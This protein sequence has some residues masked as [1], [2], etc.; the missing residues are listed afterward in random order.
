MEC[1]NT[2][3]G[4][5][6]GIATAPILFS[7]DRQPPSNFKKAGE[8]ENIMRKQYKE[9]EY[10]KKLRDPR[11]QKMRLKIL[12]RDEFTCQ[13]CMDSE[14][15]LHVHH[16]YYNKGNDPWDY[17]YTSLVTLC[18]AC[19]EVE[20]NCAYTDK[21]ALIEVLS[22]LGL[23]SRHFNEIVVSIHEARN[24]K[25]LELPNGISRDIFTSVMA[26]VFSN[27]KMRAI[28][29]EYYFDDLRKSLSQKS[30]E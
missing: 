26:W 2:L 17:P 5:G 7:L 20:T 9:T 1:V 21:N 3:H 22:S 27:R 11:W 10:S 28:A 15:T 8:S 16:C 14:S 13:S 19:H 6:S 23:L 30:E 25:E 4:G 24:S 29:E 18:E 12:E